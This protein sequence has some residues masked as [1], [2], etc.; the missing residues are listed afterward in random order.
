VIIT[1]SPIIVSF[2]TTT[3]TSHFAVSTIPGCHQSWGSFAFFMPFTLLFV[4]QLALI[5]LTLVRVIQS[6]RSAKGLLYA[7]LVKHNIFYYACGLLLSV[8]N[9]IVPVLP[10]S[11]SPSYFLPEGF[12]VFF[13]AFLATRMHL[14]L[15][16]MDHQH[17]HGSN[18][19]VCISMSDMSSVDHIV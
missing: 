6:W 10:L 19:V 4:F 1:S 7:I 18:I 12:E 3:M 14:H 9:V 13:L 2:A 8:V 11:D 17:V 5:S 16:H 15:W